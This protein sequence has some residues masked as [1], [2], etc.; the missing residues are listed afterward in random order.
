VSG[1][2]FE[3]ITPEYEAAVLLI[4]KHKV[5]EIYLKGVKYGKW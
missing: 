5:R 1:Q 3:P 4:G 2:R